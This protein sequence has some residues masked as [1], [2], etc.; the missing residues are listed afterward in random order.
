[1]QLFY[2]PQIKEGIHFLTEEESAHCVKVL[3]HKEGD[4]I[5][6]VDGL[7]TFYE[8]KITSAH[9]KKCEFDILALKHEAPLHSNIHIAIAP[10]KN[11]DRLEWF[12]EKATEIGIQEITLL[13]T[14]HSERKF[15]KTDRLEKKAVSAMKQ[16]VK[17]YMPIINPLVDFK[18][19]ISD[20]PDQ[21]NKYIAYVDE[22]LPD[23]LKD[24]APTHAS[25]CIL[26]GPEGD[27]SPEEVVQ[28]KIKNFKAVSLG[29][30]RL[31]TE[32]AAIYA[33]TV[34]NLI[35]E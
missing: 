28:A 4:V 26:I 5:H 3:R 9:H 30:S 2:Q 15:Q 23:H 17:A 7:G 35:N 10:T 27:F 24:L 16:S 19:F 14:E 22:S 13:Q 25:Y 6:I 11:A 1:M 32:T 20:V 34:L 29:K 18:K 12:V 33:C 31:R 8:A 21:I